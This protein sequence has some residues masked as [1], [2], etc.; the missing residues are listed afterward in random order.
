MPS[1]LN[2]YSIDKQQWVMQGIHLDFQHNF[3]LLIMMTHCWRIFYF[4]RVFSAYSIVVINQSESG[5][6]FW[7]DS[8]YRKQS[9]NEKKGVMILNQNI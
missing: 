7:I 3:I 6:D 8:R 4:V 9:I 2:L 5:F 1:T